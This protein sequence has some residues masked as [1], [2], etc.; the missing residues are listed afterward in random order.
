M[1]LQIQGPAITHFLKVENV[2]FFY[3]FWIGDK[4]PVFSQ[5]WYIPLIPGGWDKKI[6]S[7][8]P[9]WVIRQDPTLRNKFHSLPEHQ[10]G[11][12]HR[13]NPLPREYIET[14]SKPN[15][16][17]LSKTFYSKNSF[18]KK[19][20]WRVFKC[21][22]VYVPA[23]Y[24]C[25]FSGKPEETMALLELNRMWVPIIAARTLSG[26][27]ISPAPRILFKNPNF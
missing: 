2:T 23:P 11:G 18:K 9:A 22:G 4:I 20:F 14:S 12:L 24:A 1:D 8:R 6:L 26:W 17:L 27:A 19:I 5:C 7:P 16:A 21:A 13:P 15:S 25:M 10:S 3:S